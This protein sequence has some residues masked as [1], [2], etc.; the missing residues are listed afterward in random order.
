MDTNVMIGIIIFAAFIFGYTIGYLKNGYK[1]NVGTLWI[2]ALDP[3]NK[4]LLYLE[5]KEG[6]EY[7]MDDKDVCMDVR[8]V[9]ET[10]PTRE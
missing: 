7:F 2:D 10:A 9:Q 5:L 4:P 6:V 8:R 3:E 1:T